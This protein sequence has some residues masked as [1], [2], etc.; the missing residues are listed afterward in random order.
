MSSAA[1]AE[2]GALYINSREAIP[3]RHLLEEMG[4]KQPPTPIQ[5][6]NTTARGIVTNTIKQRKTR[7]MDMRFYWLRDRE[8]QQKYHFYWGSGKYNLGDYYTKHHLVPS[9]HIF[10]SSNV[11]GPCS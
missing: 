1:K 9:P 11:S 10:Q 4:H 2:L 3:I 8:F 5:T 7:A 6:D